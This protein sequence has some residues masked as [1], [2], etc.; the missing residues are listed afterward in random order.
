MEITPIMPPADAMIDFDMLDCMVTGPDISII[1]DKELDIVNPPSVIELLGQDSKITFFVDSPQRYLVLNFKTMDRFLSIALTCL[2][3]T[4]E[5]KSITITNRASFI[6]ADRKTC[7]VPLVIEE[8]WQYLCL[9]LEDMLANA[10]AA[11]HAVCKEVMVF[12]SCRLSKLYFQS[13]LY[14]DVELPTYLR[15]ITTNQA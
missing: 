7:K 8:G 13:K 11:S 1:E 3:D 9:D 5:M 15:T 4:G 10:F 14:S 6:T 2:D 12:G